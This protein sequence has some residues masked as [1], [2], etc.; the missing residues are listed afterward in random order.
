MP[1]ELIDLE[2]TTLTVVTVEWSYGDGNKGAKNRFFNSKNDAIQYYKEECEW[3]RQE[4]EDNIDT[5][6]ILKANEVAPNRHYYLAQRS[7]DNVYIHI[8]L[9]DYCYYQRGEDDE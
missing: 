9:L 4:F 3:A 5:N 6:Y 7:N 1:K 8:I 2:T